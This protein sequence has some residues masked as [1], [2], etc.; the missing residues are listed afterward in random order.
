MR[1]SAWI[2][3]VCR[4][5]L[6]GDG[7]QLCCEQGHCFDIAREGY[8]NLLL[9]QHKRSAAPGDDKPMLDSRRQFLEQGFYQPLCEH[10][11]ALC[12]DLF[13]K[14]SGE[15]FLVLDSGCGEGYY[16]GCIAH[17]LNKEASGREH[18]IAGIDIS[19][20]AVRMASK[21]YR[22]VDFAVA[23]NASIPVADHSLDCLLRIFAPGY[24]QEVTRTLKPNGYFVTVSPGPRHLFAL[25]E[26][27][28]D[29]VRQRAPAVAPVAGL[30]HVE[31]SNLEFEI[32]IE[33]EGNV[34]RL[35]SMTPFYWQT[36]QDKQEKIGGLDMLR[37]E[38]S[39]YIDVYAGQQRP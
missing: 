3:P 29:H 30:R 17:A 34:A 15:P 5:Q 35:L 23:S 13:R 20:H 25:R 31:R 18:W 11:A 26:L 2:C 19:K 39:F 14:R 36:S 9:A 33:G 4:T 16:T 12:V 28:Y 7:K 38:I 10:L 8:V 22:S 32:A 21:R 27:V 6:Q 24:D 37:T 1:A